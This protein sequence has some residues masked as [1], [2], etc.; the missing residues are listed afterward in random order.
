MARFVLSQGACPV[1]DRDVTRVVHTT[2]GI[3]REVFQCP[4][5]GRLEYETGIVPLSAMGYDMTSPATVMHAQLE[6]AQP[7]TGLELV[8]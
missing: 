7:M 8:Y 3:Q 6:R 1:C 5:D 4:A 2:A